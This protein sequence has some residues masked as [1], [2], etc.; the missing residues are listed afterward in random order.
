MASEVDVVDAQ[1]SLLFM[2]SAEVVEEK[3]DASFN[4]R[5]TLW[6]NFH[7]PLSLDIGCVGHLEDI[8]HAAGGIIVDVFFRPFIAIAGLLPF[9]ECIIDIR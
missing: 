2:S 4:K 6:W 8:Y 5:K 7:L 1:K 9:L 3:A